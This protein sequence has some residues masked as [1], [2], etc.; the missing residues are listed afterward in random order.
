LLI[1]LWP[2]IG[3][4]PLRAMGG[5]SRILALL[6]LCMPASQKHVY[7]K[8]DPAL[9]TFLSVCYLLADGDPHTASY[10]AQC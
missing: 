5:S 1:E 6:L 10:S 9:N 7:D 8:A 3:Y 4:D 2:C